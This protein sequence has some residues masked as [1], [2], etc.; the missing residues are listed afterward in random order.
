MDVTD[1]R[2]SRL[3]LNLGLLGAGAVALPITAVCFGFDHLIW[4]AVS[5]GIATVLMLVLYVISRGGLGF[6]D[7]ILIALGAH[8]VDG[9]ADQRLR[10][11]SSPARKSEARRRISR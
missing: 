2:E 3:P 1:A 8:L 7:V 5:C 4:A 9:R 10:G 11:S 6:G